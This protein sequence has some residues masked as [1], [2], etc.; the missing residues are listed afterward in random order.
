MRL[1]DANLQAYKK[2]SFAHSTSCILPSFSQS[3]SRLQRCFESV[4]AHFVSGNINEKYV[5]CNLPAY[6]KT[7]TQDP[8]VGSETQDPRVGPYSGTLR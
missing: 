3:A 8:N 4:R 7:G 6:R 1:R 2:N 5:T